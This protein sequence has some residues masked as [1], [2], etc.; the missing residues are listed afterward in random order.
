MQN[1]IIINEIEST[2]AVYD[3]VMSRIIDKNFEDVAAVAGDVLRI[4][5]ETGKPVTQENE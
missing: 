5:L 2:A 3:Y 4:I 1:K